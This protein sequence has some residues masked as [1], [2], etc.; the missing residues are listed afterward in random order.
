[1]A[2][3]EVAEGR[4]AAAGARHEPTSIFGKLYLQVLI[5][6][7]V[8]VAVGQYAPQAGIAAKPLGDAF[9]SLI[10]AVVPVIVFVTV[11]VGI[12]KMGDIRR[13]GI[14]GLKAIIYFEV[15]ST[16]ALLIGLGS[17]TGRSPAP[18]CT[19]ARLP[20]TPSR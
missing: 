20:S 19:S 4:M 16:I 6:I 17:A 9:I 3:T 14:V 1:V 5:A 12:A 13:V 7:T 18:G 2:Q 15:V 8:G 11:A 10:R